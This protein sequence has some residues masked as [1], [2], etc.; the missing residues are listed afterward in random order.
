MCGGRFYLSQD[1]LKSKYHGRTDIFEI[2][3]MPSL[4]FK[5]ISFFGLSEIIYLPCP[6]I[7]PQV[8][9]RCITFSLKDQTDI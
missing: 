3:E 4:C 5:Y 9:H 6:F 8:P 7:A 2:M 1:F